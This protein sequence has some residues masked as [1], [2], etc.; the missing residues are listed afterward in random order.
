MTRST[1]AARIPVTDATP[2][3][4]TGY[5]GRSDYWP[6][7]LEADP[8]SHDPPLPFEWVRPLV[9][10]TTKAKNGRGSAARE[11]GIG[12]NR[13]WIISSGPLSLPGNKGTVGERLHH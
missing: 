8:L 7:E 1:L 13:K 11:Q 6:P 5:V 9:G 2:Y 12:S 4:D 3:V 10:P